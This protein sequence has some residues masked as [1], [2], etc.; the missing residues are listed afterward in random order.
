MA[1]PT[2][3]DNVG[4]LMDAL[5]SLC[6]EAG[7]RILAIY[8]SSYSI[9][10]KTDRTPVT[11][12]DY[13]AHEAIVAGLD[14]LTP[15]TPVLSEEEPDIPFEQRRTWHRYWLV[16]PMDGTREFIRGNGQFSVN[17]VDGEPLFS[18]FCY[19]GQLQFN[20]APGGGEPPRYDLVNVFRL[21]T[22]APKEQ[23]CR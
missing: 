3:T 12:A 21:F 17:I 15:V 7:E 18:Q 11:E 2:G 6:R 5:V 22:D 4:T 10:H 9:E 8:K 23:G 20:A 19:V 1:E 16:D 13:A 14:I